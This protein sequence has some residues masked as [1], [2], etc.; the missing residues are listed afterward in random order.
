MYHSDFIIIATLLLLQMCLYQLK[1][2]NIGS[3]VHIYSKKKKKASL[4]CLSLIYHCFKDRFVITLNKHFKIVHSVNSPFDNIGGLGEWR[5]IGKLYC[6][7]HYA[8]AGEF[9]VPLFISPNPTLIILLSVQREEG[10]QRKKCGYNDSCLLP[11][12]KLI[13]GNKEKENPYV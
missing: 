2:E 4:S 13:E 12:A 5:H 6:T 1:K 9:S 8:Q 10:I 3:R 7:L 11:S